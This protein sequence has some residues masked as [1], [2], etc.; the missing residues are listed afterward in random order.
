MDEMSTYYRDFDPKRGEKRPSYAPK[1]TMPPNLKFDSES[2]YKT[3]FDA[4]AIPER[5]VRDRV[6]AQA[7]VPFEGTSTSRADYVQHQVGVRESLGPKSRYKPL[8]DDR[9]FDTEQRAQFYQKAG[10]GATRCPAV[11]LVNQQSRRKNGHTFFKQKTTQGGGQTWEACST[12]QKV[13]GASSLT[14]YAIGGTHQ[15]NVQEDQTDLA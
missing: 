1:M 13:P 2:T 10:Q 9:Q 14:G 7:S 8:R 6:K 5:Y 4:K 15:G 11:P 12:A 3:A